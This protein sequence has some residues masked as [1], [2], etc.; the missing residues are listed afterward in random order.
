MQGAA[1]RS[2]AVHVTAAAAGQH[3]HDVPGMGP[4]TAQPEKGT[5]MFDPEKLSTLYGDEEN[6]QG[7]TGEGSDGQEG[8]P[9]QGCSDN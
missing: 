8:N 4:G 9:N 3:V 5:A 1:G 7:E 6:S 2:A